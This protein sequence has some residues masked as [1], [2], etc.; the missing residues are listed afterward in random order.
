MIIDHQSRSRLIEAQSLIEQVAAD[1]QTAL[2]ARSRATLSQNP[3]PIGIG[4][5]LALSRDI[6][7]LELTG[8]ML[9][10]LLGPPPAPPRQAAPAA[11][12]R[13]A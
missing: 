8:Q 1:H 12:A 9:S 2:E 13:A 6:Q 5:M 11:E 10:H 3:G 7:A 4:R